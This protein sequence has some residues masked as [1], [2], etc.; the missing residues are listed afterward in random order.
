MEPVKTMFGRQV[1]KEN[2]KEV[3]KGIGE[4]IQKGKNKRKIA[5][6]EMSIEEQCQLVEW[7][8]K[9]RKYEKLADKLLVKAAR[10]AG[11]EWTQKIKK[12]SKNREE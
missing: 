3:S 8:G 4:G 1:E 6:L 2:A 10:R 7:E 9:I 11:I 5:I 12:L